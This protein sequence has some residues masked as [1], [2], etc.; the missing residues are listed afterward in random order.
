MKKLVMSLFAVT[1]ILF[2]AVYLVGARSES[3]IR[4]IFAQSEQQELSMQLLS[5]KRGLFRATAISRVYLTPEG[6][7]PLVFTVHSSI[8][9]YPYKAVISNEIELLDRQL[10]EQVQSYFGSDSWLTSREEINLLSGQ[11]SGKLQL[12]PGR[13]AN[14]SEQL[15]TKALHLDYQF[16]LQNRSGSFTVNLDGLFVQ[17]GETSLAVEAMALS[18]ELGALTN[19]TDYS[20]LAEIASLIILQPQTQ[21]QL[22]DIKLQGESRPGKQRD[23]LNSL[24]EWK[25]AS[26]RVSDG[27]EKVFTDNHLQLDLQG[28]SVPALT[29]LSRAA[30]DPQQ[31]AKALT[32]L[33]A[34]GA[35]L[36]MTTFTSQTPW[37]EVNGALDITLEQGAKLLEL[38]DNP[39]MLL[40]YTSGS[41]RLLLP[42]ALLQLPEVSELLEVLL[43]S[44]LLKR[45]KKRLSLETQLELGELTVNGRVIPL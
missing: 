19:A 27:S 2:A 44:G 33:V 17:T 31:A 3:E 43:E 14:D 36:S 1:V 45:E 28:L 7:A 25:I 29:L 24:N 16:D 23:T 22:Q 30:D 8:L 32:E 18:A 4:K 40:D 10:A 21:L 39:F 35:Q 38:I 42:E 11:L 12:L 37:G 41:A 13:Y 9:H 15:A 20:Y 34:H 26:Y 6:A 5:Y